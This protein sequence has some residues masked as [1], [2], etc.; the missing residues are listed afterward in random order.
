[1]ANVM[2][3]DGFQCGNSTAGAAG[4]HT[5]VPTTPAVGAANGWNDFQ[6]NVGSRH[7]S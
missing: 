7:T 5:G 6:G 2:L 3:D 1:M 4:T